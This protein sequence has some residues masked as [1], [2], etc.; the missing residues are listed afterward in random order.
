MKAKY[1]T[2]SRDKL[3]SNVYR[4]KVGFSFSGHIQQGHSTVKSTTF[5]V[6]PRHCASSHTENMSGIGDVACR[7][8][9]NEY[10]DL[11]IS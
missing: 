5:R 10:V 7:L 2:V 3:F 11:E 6:Q 4:V 1:E 8:V 9:Q